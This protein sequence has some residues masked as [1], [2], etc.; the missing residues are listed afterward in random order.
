MQPTT[1]QLIQLAL[2]SGGFLLGGALLGALV[3]G[4]YNLRVKRHEYINDY[5][6]TVIQRRIAAYEQLE[7]LIACFRAAVVGKDR[8]PYHLTLS[9]EAPEEDIFK[10]LFAVMS[11]GLW[12]SDEAFAKIT[13][14]N[15]LLFG[16]PHVEGDVIDF[17]KQ[18][19]QAIATLRD[20][21]ERILAADVLELHDVGRFLKR[22][23]N[24]NDPGF[25]PVQLI[26]SQGNSKK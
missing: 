13:E 20:A 16:V 3:A 26:H 15:Y 23:K 8:K 11:Q 17:G 2:I 14:L 9:G 4:I 7:G 24:R 12:L 25:H 6:K 5:Y 22:K 1:H 19:Y 18:N 21:L 10:R